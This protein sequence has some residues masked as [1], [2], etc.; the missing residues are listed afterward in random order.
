M[1][2]K[3]I[4]GPGRREEKDGHGTRNSTDV[5]KKEADQAKRTK[6]TRWRKGWRKGVK[7]KED[8]GKME[9]VGRCWKGRHRASH[10]TGRR[11]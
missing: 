10:L 8:N 6:Q 5:S 1:K 7:I 3:R 11:R 4:A 2:Q 9:D